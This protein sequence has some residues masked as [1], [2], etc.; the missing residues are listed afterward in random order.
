MTK[1][2]DLGAWLLPVDQTTY[3]AVGRHELKYIEY[4][5][6]CVCLPGLPSYCEQG[7]LWR[8]RFIPAL[9][10]H[11]LMTHTRQKQ[12]DQEKMAAIVAYENALGQIDVGAIFLQGVPKLLPIT[13]QQSVAIS[14]LD[15]PL[16]LLAHA[17]FE[18]EQKSYP[19]LDL[20]ALFDQTPADLFAMH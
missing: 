13:P 20:R 15:L 1:T 9:D 6:D 8:D 5:N 3:V 16:Q 18:H 4:V 7:F 17:A 19:V 10:I 2:Q 14:L 11:Q 12:A